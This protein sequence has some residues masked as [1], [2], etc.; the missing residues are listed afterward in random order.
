MIS[1]LRC[2]NWIYVDEASDVELSLR[3]LNLCLRAVEQ[4]ARYWKWAIISVHNAL[5]G[6]M[7]CHLS[8]TA[9]VGCLDRKSFE[10]WYVWNEKDR[11]GEINWIHG[12]PDELGISVRRPATK[13]DARPKEFLAKPHELFRRLYAPRH[14]IEPGCGAILEISNQQR[15]SFKMVNALRN[16]FAHFLPKGW[17]IEVSGLPDALSDL[18]KIIR[19]I[20]ADDWPFRHLESH[21]RS[22][23]NAEIDSALF[24]LGSLI[25]Q[26]PASP[27]RRSS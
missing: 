25:S 9:N 17:S 13:D 2:D 21:Q 12:E 27:P 8:G 11:R 23:L 22:L 10:A 26:R 16:E 5:Q 19:I 6:A 14:R 7:T 4:D 18:L 15:R 1:S 3:H 20:A 24:S